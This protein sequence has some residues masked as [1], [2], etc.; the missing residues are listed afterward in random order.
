MLLTHAIGS[1][2]R[3]RRQPISPLLGFFF[4]F[5]PA[6]SYGGGGVVVG[7]VLVLVLVWVD[8]RRWVAE[9]VNISGLWLG[10]SALV[11]CGWLRRH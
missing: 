9:F 1:C 2:R 6:V 3:H 4:F 5:P 8:Q 11:G 10:S 7:V